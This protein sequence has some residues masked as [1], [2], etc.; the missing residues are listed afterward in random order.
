MR[1]VSGICNMCGRLAR[2]LERSKGWSVV[3]IGV[4]QLQMH[5]ECA[6]Q[7]RGDG[8]LPTATY[9]RRTD[10]LRERVERANAVETL[11]RRR[12]RPPEGKLWFGGLRDERALNFH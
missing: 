2:Q 12:P 1:T 4:T 8:L 6:E 10:S 3:Q 9:R 11:P 7:Y 5:H